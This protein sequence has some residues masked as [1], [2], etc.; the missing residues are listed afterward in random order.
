MHPGLAQ[1]A[2]RANARQ[3]GVD[4]RIEAAS[5][6][7]GHMPTVLMRKILDAQHA[8]RLLPGD[9]DRASSAIELGKPV[10]RDVL[11]RI[12]GEAS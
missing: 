5:N 11:A 7:G 3:R 2:R 6:N 9:I 4:K 12:L 10:P 8:R 1:Q